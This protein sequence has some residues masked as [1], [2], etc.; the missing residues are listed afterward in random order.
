MLQNIQ[1]YYMYAPLANHQKVVIYTANITLENWYEYYNG[2]L[3]VMKDSIELEEIHRTM[4]QLIFP[5]QE[6]IDISIPDLFINLI[7]WFPIVSL[8]ETI[9][10][11]HLLIKETFTKIY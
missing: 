7:L 8:K 9:G 5:T 4:I 6:S 2:L 10:P 11:Q 3:N 1:N